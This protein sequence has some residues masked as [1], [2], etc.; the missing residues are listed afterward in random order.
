MSVDQLRLDP[1]E[2]AV[3]EWS[4]TEPAVKFP[5]A[6]GR[7]RTTLLEQDGLLRQGEVPICRNEPDVAR[8]VASQFIHLQGY[9]G[10]GRWEHPF[11]ENQY[12]IH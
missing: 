2:G 5:A 9:E 8:G 6:A 1:R 10:L 3:E 4:Y 12:C 11:R 7:S